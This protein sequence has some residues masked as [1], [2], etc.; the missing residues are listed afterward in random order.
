MKTNGKRWETRKIGIVYRPIMAGS[1]DAHLGF[2]MLHERR[3][4]REDPIA[5]VAEC[6]FFHLPPCAE[7]CDIKNKVLDTVRS[8]SP[9]TACRYLASAE[10]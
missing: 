5:V 2:L 4:I 3:L 1:K 7:T 10:K 6:D 9:S 8:Y